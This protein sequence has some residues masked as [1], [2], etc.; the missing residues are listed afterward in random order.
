MTLAQPAVPPPPPVSE[1]SLPALT[2]SGAKRDLVLDPPWTNAAGTLG[3]SD[4]A[5]RLVDLA[6]LGALVTNPISLAPRTPARGPR[7]LRYPGGFALHTGH[8]NPGLSEV[9]RRH[10]RRWARLPC[11]V[12]VH[13]LA[14]TADEVRRMVERLEALDEVAG[15][16]V[17]LGDADAPLAAALVSAAV[18]SQRPVL[19]QF[20]FTAPESVAHAAAEAGAAALV[21]GAPRGALPAAGGRVRG[22][23]YGPGLLPLLLHA[24]EG[25]AGEAYAPLIAGAAIDSPAAHDAARAAGARAVQFDSALWQ[26]PEVVLGSGRMLEG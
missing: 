26:A 1:R 17:G 22:R 25:L 15:L 2:L 23:L 8:P 20:P 9:L 4:E 13:L 5:R 24:L 21:L 3:F 12:I 6:R 16:E 10:R 7:L 19:A 14:S 18:A 11:P